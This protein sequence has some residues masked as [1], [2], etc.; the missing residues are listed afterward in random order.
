[1]RDDGGRPDG[2]R[3]GE[4][5]GAGPAIRLVVESRDLPE[6]GGSCDAGPGVGVRVQSRCDGLRC[7]EDEGHQ[8]F[9]G[10][11]QQGGDRVD[12]GPVGA[13]DQHGAGEGDA[14]GPDP[15]GEV[16]PRWW[17]RGQAACAV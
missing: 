3:H 4:R 15:V 16:H 12:D 8:V 9:A 17:T 11:F 2:D 1:M 6:G 5:L 14:K 13:V 10:V 7:G